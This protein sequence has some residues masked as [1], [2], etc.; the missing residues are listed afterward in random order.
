MHF[1]ELKSKFLFYGR[2]LTILAIGLLFQNIDRSFAIEPLNPA[3]SH[4]IDSLYEQAVR[5][6]DYD[7]AI[8]GIVAYVERGDIGVSGQAFAI[9]KL[10]Q[11]AAPEL[12]SYLL[13]IAQSEIEFKNSNILASLAHRAY[14]ATL[15]AEAADQREDE[16]ILVEGLKATASIIV[17]GREEPISGIKSTLVREWAID[18]LCRRGSSEHFQNIIKAVNSYISGERGQQKIDLCRRQMELINMFESDL[19]AFEHILVT[20]D[21]TSEKK[22][23]DWALEE[24][25]KLNAI[26]TDDIIFNYIIRLRDE[27]NIRY[28]KSESILYDKPIHLL[29]KRK[30]T[31]DDFK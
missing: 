14:W 4:A 2:F 26:E 21:P 3:T 23:I 28:D 11:L 9:S 13:G 16:L 24:L 10:E 31:Y 15:L 25:A 20:V 7:A 30:W 5:G 6:E 1:D 22:L 27:L 18:G 17:E 12:K 19:V 8:R 29:E